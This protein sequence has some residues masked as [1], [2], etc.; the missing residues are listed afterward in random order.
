[1]LNDAGIESFNFDTLC[2]FTHFTGLTRTDVAL[3]PDIVVDG[4]AFLSACKRRVN[5]VPLQYILGEWQFMG[6]DFKVTPDVLI[7]RADTEMLVEYI[8]SRY[9]DKKPRVLD[10][11]CGSGCIGLAVKHFL[12]NA[13]VTL[14]DISDR[15]LEI[16]RQN[17]KKLSLCVDIKNADLLKGGNAYFENGAFD[18]IVS[19]PPYISKSDMQRLS[20]EVLHEPEI[21]LY[22]GEDGTDF[23]RALINLWQNTLSANGEMILESGYDT[24]RDIETFF[25]ECGYI[26]IQK[27]KDLN[28]IYRLISAKKDPCV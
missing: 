19:N 14:C 1:M 6:L 10:M 16:T 23:Y 7:P 25:I 5:G 18:V 9:K 8:I 2:L 21:A 26:D 27:R 22:G 20:K 3:T 4:A 28:G 15:A 24:A 17:A 12:P 11:C 13:S